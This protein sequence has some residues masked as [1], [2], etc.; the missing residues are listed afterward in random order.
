ML[1]EAEKTVRGSLNTWIIL[2]LIAQRALK[3]SI[4]DLLSLFFALQIQCYMMKF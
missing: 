3:S 4:D 2:Q 1:K